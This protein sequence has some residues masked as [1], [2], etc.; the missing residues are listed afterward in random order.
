MSSAA[1]RLAAAEASDGLLRCPPAEVKG[2][3]PGNL[4]GVVWR[5]WRT[6]RALAARG[7]AFR[8]TD[9]A[10]VE[11]AYAAMSAEEFDAVNGRQ[12]W[13][14]WRTIPASL[15]MLLPD[16]PLKAVDLGCG[17]GGST[18]VLAYCLPDGSEVTGVEFAAPLAAVA[19]GR[20]YPNRAGRC[21]VRFA[22]G[23][24]CS[25]LT[26][27]DGRPFADGAVDLV[28]SS[29]VIG[30]HLTGG[31]LAACLD[32][33][34]RVL[35]PGGVAALDP[36]PRLSAGRLTELTTARGLRRV[37]RTRSNPFDRCGQVVFVR[38]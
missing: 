12:A 34:A 25:P 6:E 9:P 11:A 4:A 20:E 16:T 8:S 21:T 37:R 14:N 26:D 13:A 22:V 23:S 27:A 5:Q 24:V 30:H 18:A 31:D 1:L 7:V 35:R 29:G 2:A 32:E 28:N 15:D 10:A 3:G 36:G 38:T 17:T 19:G 33:T